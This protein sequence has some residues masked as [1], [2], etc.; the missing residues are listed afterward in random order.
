[1]LAHDQLIPSVLR[2]TQVLNY[3]DWFHTNKSWWTRTLRSPCSLVSTKVSEKFPAWKHL[4]SKIDLDIQYKFD[5]TEKRHYREVDFH[6]YK[7]TPVGFV[8]CCE[9]A[10]LIPLGDLV[11]NF[12][13][14]EQNPE[15]LL[16]GSREEKQEVSRG[17][18]SL[19]NTDVLF[20]KPHTYVSSIHP[21]NY[22]LII[23]SSEF[24]KVCWWF[25]TP[26]Y[27]PVFIKE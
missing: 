8:T 17:W 23:V 10:F 26:R 14:I 20:V 18:V 19:N 3:I 27:D 13:V 16:N 22:I 24:D 4:E 21:Q 6:E 1:M 15:R 12:E 9:T 7:N 11:V 25:Q 2:I 5:S